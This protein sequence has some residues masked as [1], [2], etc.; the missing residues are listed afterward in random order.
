MLRRRCSAAWAPLA[1][2]VTRS[3]GRHR[4]AVCPRLTEGVSPQT[5]A[6][7][8]VASGSLCSNLCQLC[9]SEVPG[10]TA[11]TS[12]SADAARLKL[13]Q[14]LRAGG[15]QLQHC[16][17]EVRQNMLRLL[18]EMSAREQFALAGAPGVQKLEE[19]LCL[20]ITKE[21]ASWFQLPRRRSFAWARRCPEAGCCHRQSVTRCS[22]KAV[23]QLR[24]AFE[25]G[26]VAYTWQEAW[27]FE[28]GLAAS[29]WSAEGLSSSLLCQL[30]S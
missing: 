26:G 10:E 4:L 19:A 9:S 29:H 23:L 5:C 2:V 22:S 14:L 30:S 20:S 18:W 12:S 28:H 17:V 24:P 16:E 3:F 11:T 27:L 1:L 21:Q 6:T 7:T 15:L 8:S 13:L 25:A